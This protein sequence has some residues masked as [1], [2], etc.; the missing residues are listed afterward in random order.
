MTWSRMRVDIIHN[1][2][3]TTAHA[4]FNAFGFDY[5]M[6][7]LITARIWI[8]INLS[9][10]FRLRNS[11]TF[12]F[13]SLFMLI[14]Y[15]AWCFFNSMINIVALGFA[16]SVTHTLLLICHLWNI[17]NRSRAVLI[18][19]RHLMYCCVKLVIT[20]LLRFG[21]RICWGTRVIHK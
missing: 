13:F 3:I 10:C 15:W 19:V 20:F 21:K 6:I 16:D 5:V 2:G 14:M 17:I 11:I 4:K 18:F 8:L 1:T 7:R 9:I 12:I